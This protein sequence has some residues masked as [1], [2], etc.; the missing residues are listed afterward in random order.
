MSFS[1]MISPLLGRVLLSWFFLAAAIGIVNDFEGTSQLMMLR[2]VPAPQLMLVIVLMVLFLGGLSLL[3]GFHARAGA[4]MLF[5]FTMV[6]SVLWHDYWHVS[7]LGER[8]AHYEIFIRNM[9][10]AGACL[11]IVGMGP[12]AFSLDNALGGGGKRR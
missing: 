6:V 12:G 5:A 10:I 4:L 9:A 2:H 7:N 11:F 1:E 3:F 8:E